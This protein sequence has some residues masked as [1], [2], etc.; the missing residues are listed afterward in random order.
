MKL[1]LTNSHACHCVI[2]CVF[3]TFLNDAIVIRYVLVFVTAVYGRRRRQCARFND[4]TLPAGNWTAKFDVIEEGQVF[5]GRFLRTTIRIAKTATASTSI[6]A[7][8][9]THV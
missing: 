6:L 7:G 1:N 8:V 9:H 4:V 2:V 5:F 3:F